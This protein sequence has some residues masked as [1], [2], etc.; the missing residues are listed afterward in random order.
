MGLGA[1]EEKLP[2]RQEEATGKLPGPNATPDI[3]TEDVAESAAASDPTES[4]LSLFT[5][6]SITKNC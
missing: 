3:A 2:A 1:A 5:S 4:T 6:L